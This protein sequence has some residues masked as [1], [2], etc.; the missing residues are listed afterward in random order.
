MFNISNSN[1][2]EFYQ[3]YNKLLNDHSNILEEVVKERLKNENSKITKLGLKLYPFKKIWLRKKFLKPFMSNFSR[4]EFAK[5]LFINKNKYEEVFEL[6]EDELSKQTLL[7][8]MCFKITNQTSY[9]TNYLQFVIDQYFDS[10]I[11]KNEPMGEVFVDCGAFIG[12]TAYTFKKLNIPLKSYY[13]LEPNP[14]SLALAKQY[15]KKFNDIT[16]LP[17]AVGNKKDELSF[18]AVGASSHIDK[19]GNIKVEVD[20]ID[21]IISE[22]ITFIKMDVEG[23][24]KEALLGT[25]KHIQTTKPKLAISA[26]HR[27]NDVWKLVETIK[28]I[29]DDYKFFLRVYHSSYCE[30][31]LYAV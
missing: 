31:V 24:E 11:I 15:L 14:Q 18:S 1:I 19:T 30:A 20:A 7:A 5:D 8:I 9:L 27:P 13:F 16:Y 4:Y 28:S 29:R 23:F 26:Y 12:D 25:K 10:K 21:N 3:H 17:L 22:K 2:T 6:L